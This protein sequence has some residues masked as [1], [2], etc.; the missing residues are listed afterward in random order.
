MYFGT[1][2]CLN[3]DELKASYLTIYLSPDHSPVAKKQFN[4]ETEK[5]YEI[6]GSQ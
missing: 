6:N 1:S 5:H 2:H 3:N 4:E